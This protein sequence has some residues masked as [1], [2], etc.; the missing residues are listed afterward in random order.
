MH[1]LRDETQN[2][3]LRVLENV[4]YAQLPNWY[5]FSKFES[6]VYQYIKGNISLDDA[7]SILIAEN[8]RTI[9]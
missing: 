7:Y 2:E 4:E 1:P 6:V 5:N 8:I 3:V 9:E